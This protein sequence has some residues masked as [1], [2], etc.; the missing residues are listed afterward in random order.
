MSVAFWFIYAK[1][2]HL[3]NNFF[4]PK[5]LKKLEICNYSFG[6]VIAISKKKIGEL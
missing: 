2:P 1:L 6:M 4:E 5:I 3:K